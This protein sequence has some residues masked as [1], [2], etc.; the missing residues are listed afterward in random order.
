MSQEV[1][2]HLFTSEIYQNF[3]Y[4]IATRCQC[5]STTYWDGTICMRS[6]FD[7][8]SILFVMLYDLFT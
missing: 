8:Q 7:H 4:I 1:K 2:L 3:V 5:N 6:K